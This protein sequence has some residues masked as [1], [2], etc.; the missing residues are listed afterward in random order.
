MSETKKK[1]AFVDLTNFKDWPM[2]GMLE[3]ELAILKHLVSEYDVDIWGVSVDG[4]VN[5]SLCIAG[6]DYPIHIFANVKTIKKVLPN[7]WRGLEIKKQKNIFPKDYDIVYAHTGS[8]LIPVP[9]MIDRT[10]TKLIYHQHGLSHRADYSLMSLIQRPILSKAQKIADLVFVV[11][12]P[13]S[14]KEYAEEMKHKTKAK[15]VS[16]GSPINLSRF[17]ENKIQE[18]VSSHGNTPTNNFLY[19]GRLSAFKDVKTLVNAMKFYTDKVNRNAVLK[20]AGSG[21]EFEN[22]KKQVYDL[23]LENNVKLL[24]PVS[25]DDVYQLLAEA[26]VFL[27]ASGGEGVSVSVLEAYASGLPVVCFKVPGLERQIIDEVTGVFAKERTPESF[28]EAM[29]KLDSIRTDAAHNCLAEA[30]KYDSELIAGKIIDEIEK[31]FVE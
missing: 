15:F 2:G 6:T 14:V 28:C 31:L 16:I 9:R 4:K 29:V 11:S 26:D 22:L 18:K 27:T 13:A 24:G 8:C 30:K 3:Y 5:S 1:M 7:Y 19:T 25:H 21:A 12:D 10:K 17:D 23:N 20:V